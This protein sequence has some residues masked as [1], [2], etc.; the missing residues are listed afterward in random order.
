[1]RPPEQEV[2][3]DWP[4]YFQKFCEKHGEPVPYRGRLLFPD[5]FMYSATDHAGPEYFPDDNELP[6][7]KRA[8]W[9]TRLRMV[10]AEARALTQSIDSYLSAQSSRS[11]PL[12]Q[13]VVYR[14]SEDRTRYETTEVDEL[15]MRERLRWLIDDIRECREQLAGVH[16]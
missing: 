5:G 12:Q 4:A 14:D 13:T 6:R 2:E 7:L 15:A 3:L 8:Y 10:R 11:V 9:V 1:M 16:A